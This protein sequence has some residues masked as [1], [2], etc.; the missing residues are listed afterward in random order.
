MYGAPE[1]ES[2]VHK[3][4]KE[5]NHCV[6]VTYRQECPR[7]ERRVNC[8]SKEQMLCCGESRGYGGSLEFIWSL[9]GTRGDFHGQK[10]AIHNL[11]LIISPFTV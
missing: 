6:P 1:T 3:P 10:H 11:I 8:K 7:H 5:P 2:N 9:K 4:A